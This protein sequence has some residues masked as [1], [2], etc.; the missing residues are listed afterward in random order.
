MPKRFKNYGLWVSVAALGGLFVN[1]LGLLAPD[2]YQ[3]YVD[4]ILAVLVA[5][6]IINNPSLGK[7]Y[8]DQ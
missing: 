7:G 1:D 5:G 6:G 8:K 3:A 2:K 4:A